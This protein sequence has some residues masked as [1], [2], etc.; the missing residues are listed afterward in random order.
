MKQK[1][2]AWVRTHK[3]ISIA[4][5]IV[6]IVGGFFTVNA[7]KGSPTQYVVGTVAKGDLIITVNGTGE[8]QAE[9]QVDL[10]PQGTTQSAST[11]T[12]VDVK[13]GDSVTK[14]RADRGN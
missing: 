14:R 4:V 11:I 2:F 9:N 3:I 1:I 10:K 6:L 7:G 8:V 13:Q 5:V 12:E